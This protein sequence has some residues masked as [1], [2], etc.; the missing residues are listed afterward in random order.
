NGHV[1]MVVASRYRMGE[2]YH[3]RV[4]AERN[5]LNIESINLLCCLNQNVF[6]VGHLFAHGG[7]GSPLTQV[8]RLL[9]LVHLYIPEV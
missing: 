9:H 8:V 3:K 7:N 4:S 2:L 1:F 5:D 6:R